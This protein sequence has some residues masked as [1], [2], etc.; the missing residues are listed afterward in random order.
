MV[1]MA[2]KLGNG[3]RTRLRSRPPP[4]AAVEDIFFEMYE[5]R[6]WAI[7]FHKVVAL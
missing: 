6:E 4:A 1:E 2:A 3:H 7:I 5:G